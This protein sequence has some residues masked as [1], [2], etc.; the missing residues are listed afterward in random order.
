M[1]TL[2]IDV[3]DHLSNPLP[4]PA[5]DLKREFHTSSLTGVLCSKV[6]LAGRLLLLGGGLG[7]SGVPTAPRPATA[8]YSGSCWT[9]RGLFRLVSLSIHCFRRWGLDMIEG[10]LY[11]SSAFVFGYEPDSLLSQ[12]TLFFCTRRLPAGRATLPPP[13]L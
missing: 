6:W 9:T 3:I 2:G 4:S 12:P 8:C 5:L 1:D 11:P 7:G 10:H 13:F